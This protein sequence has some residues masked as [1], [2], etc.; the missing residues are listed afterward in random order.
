M[1]HQTISWK[2]KD[3]ADHKPRVDPWQEG[4]GENGQAKLQSAL[5]L[6]TGNLLK[7]QWK[8]Y[9]EWLSQ[10]VQLHF[11]DIKHPTH[12]N[13][14]S[15][16]NYVNMDTERT[17]IG[18]LATK[19][20][21]G[22]FDY[23]FVNTVPDLHL[24]LALEFWN[25]AHRV[26][27]QKPQDTCFPLIRTLGS[28]TSHLEFLKRTFVWDHYRNK[29]SV[30]AFFEHLPKRM[31]EYGQIKQVV[32]FITESK[33]IHDEDSRIGSLRFG[34]VQDLGVHMFSVFLESLLRADRWNLAPD[35]KRTQKRTGATITLDHVTKW[36][37]QHAPIPSEAE[38]FAALDFT[39]HETIARMN[40]KG[41]RADSEFP[42]KFNVLVVLGK[43]VF[44]AP[45]ANR[46][47]K[48]IVVEYEKPGAMSVIDLSSLGVSG[49]EGN[50]INYHHGGL[51]RPLNLLAPEPSDHALGG[52]GGLRYPQWQPFRFAEQIASVAHAAQNWPCSDVP[53]YEYGKPL[54]Y[55]I[56]E[57][58]SRG[59]IADCYKGLADMPLLNF[60]V[61]RTKD[62]IFFD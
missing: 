53:G 44:P 6:G 60:A 30:A 54:P 3:F 25:V 15:R 11:A 45:G 17:S 29:G 59:L 33:N 55:F 61:D 27:I 21:R 62:P 1:A 58:T 32:L 14:P 49:L 7:R 35:D 37:Q 31:S 8:A 20:K 48:T 12:V 9:E 47:L 41:G 39:V 26:I 10:G 38:T 46:D 5:V 34:M 50:N 57:L 56:R 2:L 51:N 42:H 52:L 22:K 16:A 18:Q 24:A 40:E 23:V 13:I 28:S 4:L 36:R 19:T 43:G